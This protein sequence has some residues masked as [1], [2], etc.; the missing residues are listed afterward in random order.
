MR[1]DAQKE[2]S[3]DLLLLAVETDGLGDGQDVPFIERTIER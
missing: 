3:V 2:R 1:V